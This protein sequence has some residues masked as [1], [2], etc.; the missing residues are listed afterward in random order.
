MRGIKTKL[1]IT[2]LLPTVVGVII[3][4]IVAVINITQ[5]M[6]EQAVNGLTLL[7]ESTKASY[8]NAYMGDWR[9]DNNGNMF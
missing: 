8:E 2:S 3:V 1:I 7:G 9:V 5:G 6:N 4:L